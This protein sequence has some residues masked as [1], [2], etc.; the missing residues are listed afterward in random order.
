M[1]K[2]RGSLR[3]IDL[4]GV[5]YQCQSYDLRLLAYPS[6]EPDRIEQVVGE[7]L[8][9]G[10]EKLAFQQTA[11]KY[12]TYLLGKGGRGMVFL[13]LHDTELVAV[14]VLRTDA[15]VKTMRYEAANQTYA[16][17]AGIGPKLYNWSEN[18]IVMNYIE[19]FHLGSFLTLAKSV[20]IL[21]VVDEVFEQAYVLDLI[22]LDHGQLANSSNHVII[23]CHGKAVIIDFSHSSQTRKPKN[24]TSFASYLLNTLPLLN[25]NKKLLI[26]LLKQYKSDPSKENI[27]RLKD[28]FKQMF[29]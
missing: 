8:K 5:T 7:I 13:G 17:K 3:F 6:A 15:A 26:E 23:P 21:S 12:V 10:V 22:H 1:S 19:G 11:E 28:F 14:K 24:V 20:D 4:T 2:L 18:V 25:T 9:N 29:V 27:Q 16:N